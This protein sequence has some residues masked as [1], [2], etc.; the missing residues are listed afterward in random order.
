MAK[1]IDYDKEHETKDGF[2]VKPGDTVW[3]VYG[4]IAYIDCVQW[5][6]AQQ[7]FYVFGPINTSVDKCFRM[8][9]NA[10][11]ETGLLFPR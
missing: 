6:V 8:Y 2:L 9:D 1:F 7:R 10:R 11:M 5:S 3:I 4:N